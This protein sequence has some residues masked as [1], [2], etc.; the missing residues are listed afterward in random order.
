MEER[1]DQQLVK[2]SLDGDRA[3][4]EV[5]VHRHQDSVFGLA[6]GM[7]RNR[8]DAADMAQDAF[9]RAYTKLEQYNPDYSFKSWL[10]RICANQT[11]N[12]FRK[13]TRRRETEEKCLKI[14]EVEASAEVP[15]F[16]ALEEALAGLAPKFSAPVRLKYMEGLAYEE[17]SRILGIGVSAAKMRVLRGRKQLAE[18]LSHE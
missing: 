8:E 1:T 5:L 16:Q 9:V 11:K 14:Q 18:I 2:A 10:L 6:V 3:A 17:I 4:F 12:L 13:R 15:D 7:T